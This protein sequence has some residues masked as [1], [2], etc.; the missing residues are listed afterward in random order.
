MFLYLLFNGSES[1]ERISLIFWPDSPIKQVRSNFHTTL[2]RARQ[3]LGEN[4]INHDDG[5][6]FINPALSLWCDALEL[7]DLIQQARLMPLRDARTEN[8][9]LKSS[10]LYRGDFLPFSDH[11]WV[12]FRRQNLFDNYIEALI[13]LGGCARARNN[14]REALSA[15]RRVLDVD[16]YSEN[17]H[18]G[19]MLCYDDLGE[20]KQALAQFNNLRALLYDELGVEPSNETLDLAERLLE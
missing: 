19:I 13:G 3:A 10:N 14:P 4:V 7:E 17:A 1:R 18:R 20:K 15:F 11:E 2:Y 16:P 5:L 8:L 6:Y 12:L 9:W